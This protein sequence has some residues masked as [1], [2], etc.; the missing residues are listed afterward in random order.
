MDDRREDHLDPERP[1]KKNHNEQ[2]WNHNMPTHD[3]EN[4][5]W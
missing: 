1:P 3:V 4:T 2:L 5:H